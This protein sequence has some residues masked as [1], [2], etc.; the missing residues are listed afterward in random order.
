MPSL[1][2]D[3][4]DPTEGS[5]HRA[6]YLGQL[7]SEQPPLA[8]LFS[9]YRSMGLTYSVTSGIRDCVHIHSQDSSWLSFFPLLSVSPNLNIHN[10]FEGTMGW[11]LRKYVG[12]DSTSGF[13]APCRCVTLG[14]ALPLSEPQLF[15][16]GD[17]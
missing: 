11:Q 14:K 8:P 10:C 13:F 7:F 12:L 17:F 16:L 5:T 6:P 1:E 15:P 2:G 9:F 3:E 4:N